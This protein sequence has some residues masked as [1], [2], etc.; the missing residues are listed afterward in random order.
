MRR[1]LSTVH[2]NGCNWLQLQP[3]ESTFTLTVATATVSVDV[4]SNERGDTDGSYNA[5]SARRFFRVPITYA[6]V[7]K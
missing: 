5:V 1:L 3:L 4:D 2:N 7:E 6:L